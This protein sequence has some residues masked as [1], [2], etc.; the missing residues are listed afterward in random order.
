MNESPTKNASPKK[1]AG[2]RSDRTNEINSKKKGAFEFRVND[3]KTWALG[4]AVVSLVVLG[5]WGLYLILP[6]IVAFLLLVFMFYEP[7]KQVQPNADYDYDYDIYCQTAEVAFEPFKNVSE[8]I[9][10]KRPVS[11]QDTT[12]SEWKLL[13]GN[14]YLMKFRLRKK[15]P[16]E[17][18][19]EAISFAKVSLQR[20]LIDALCRFGFQVYWNG[21]P[22]LMLDDI[23]DMGHY[24]LIT[25]GFVNNPNVYNYFRNKNKPQSATPVQ[26]KDRN[27]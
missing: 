22:M 4:F 3:P 27:F 12:L 7:R 20:D 26:V 6:F 23:K 14:F 10:A 25:V 19:E 13:M 1:G 9:D 5:I 16:T 15:S 8:S 2:V 24:F 17:V 21:M 11:V 18:E